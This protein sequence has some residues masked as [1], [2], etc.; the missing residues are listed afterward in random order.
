MSVILSSRPHEA[1]AAFWGDRSQAAY[2]KRK[3]H[4]P[5]AFFFGEIWADVL[6]P[7][8]S[9]CG[10]AV[11]RRSYSIW[12]KDGR[13][14][15]ILHPTVNGRGYCV[16]GEGIR[17]ANFGNRSGVRHRRLWCGRMPYG[18]V[19]AGFLWR[20]HD[21]GRGPFPYRLET[22]Y[23]DLMEILAFLKPERLRWK[24]CSSIVIKTAISVAEARG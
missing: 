4:V 24:S 5:F 12:N 18:T 10:K 8:L 3:L 15:F 17:C 21:G 14:G 13:I 11:W 1:R 2:W 16:A 22:I 6:C 19:S 23:R 7:R 20:D 9:F